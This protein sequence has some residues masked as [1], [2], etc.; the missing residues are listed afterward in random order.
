MLPGHA[1]PT[2]TARF[3][4]RF[5]QFSETG[6]FRHPQGVAGAS[7]LKLSSIGLGT[8]LGEPDEASDRAY[9]EAIVQAVR[10][11]V[12]VLDIAIN[13]RHQRSERNIGGAIEQL[14]E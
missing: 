4:D 11:G 2:G 1:S 14:S 8:Y 3:C 7:E 9:T 12:N 10:S 5:P 13:Y 6:H